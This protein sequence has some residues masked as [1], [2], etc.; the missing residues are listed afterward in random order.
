MILVLTV[1]LFCR[2][3]VKVDPKELF[4]DLKDDP[5]SGDAIRMLIDPYLYPQW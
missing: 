3:E 2:S 5:T 1:I 4:A